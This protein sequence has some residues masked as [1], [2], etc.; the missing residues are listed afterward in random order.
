MYRI[1]VVDDDPNIRAALKFRLERSALS[2][3]IARDGVEA[4]SM[5][6]ID[7]PHLMLL[8]LMLPEIDGFEVL[9]RLKADQSTRDI[10]VIVLTAKANR[11]CRDRSYALGADAFVSKPFSPRRLVAQ[12]LALLGEEPPPAQE[13][14]P[15]PAATL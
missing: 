9:R 2:V 6:Q 5:V 7:P 1:L 11:A 12:I 10:S 13:R 14:E 4:L 15:V 8:D 3:T